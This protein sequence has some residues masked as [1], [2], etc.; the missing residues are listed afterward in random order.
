MEKDVSDKLI[1][2]V[3]EEDRITGYGEKIMVHREGLLHRAFSVVIINSKG[4]WLMHRRALEKYHSGGKWTNTCCSH[5][6]E[7]E[8]MATAV[9]QRLQAEMG[10]DA[11]PEFVQAF[12]YRA[13]FDNG[14]IENEIDHVYVARWDGTPDPDPEEVMDWKWNSAEEIEKEL[15]KRPGDFSAW[16]PRVFHLLKPVLSD[17]T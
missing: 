11:S 8:R 9:R 5:L 14:L 2:L 17:Q 13:E 6:A 7:G 1:A 10:I 3:D 15:V 16:F 4:Q 12:H